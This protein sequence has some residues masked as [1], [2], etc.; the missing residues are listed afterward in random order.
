MTPRESVEMTNK[1]Q[2][3]SK[4]GRFVEAY[5]TYK[6]VNNPEIFYILGI[7]AY[8]LDY[9]AIAKECF[10]RGAKFGTQ[11]DHKY[12]DTFFA[13][14]IGQCITLLHINNLLNTTN[15]EDLRKTFAFGY[16]YLSSSIKILW[17]QSLRI[18]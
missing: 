11:G 2:A 8:N 14:S 10:I 6:K 4:T 12:Y 7:N 9:D 15:Q 5:E 13:N 16:L 1:I 3:L 17:K 18:A